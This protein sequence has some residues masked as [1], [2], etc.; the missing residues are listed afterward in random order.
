MTMVD[1]FKVL[2]VEKL[3][4]LQD[5]VKAYPSDLAFQTVVP[6]TQNSAEVLCQHIIGNLHHFIGA[7]L[8]DTGYERNRNGEFESHGYSRE[9]IIDSLE[10]TKDMLSS[11]LAKVWNQDLTETYPLEFKEEPLTVHRMLLILLSHLDYHRGQINYGRRIG[12]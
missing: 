8:G 4:L 2:F 9:T 11:V 5:E 3:S 6:G 1:D 10:E 7:T 12:R